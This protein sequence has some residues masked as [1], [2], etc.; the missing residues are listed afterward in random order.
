MQGTPTLISR[1]VFSLSPPYWNWTT[2]LFASRTVP[3]NPAFS[4]WRIVISR[5]WM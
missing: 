4:D 3:S 5:L 2:P 1:S